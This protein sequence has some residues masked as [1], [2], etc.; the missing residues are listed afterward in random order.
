VK[1]PGS[2]NVFV[3]IFSAGGLLFV[4]A[5]PM[6]E[7]I[8]RARGLTLAE[9]VRRYGAAGKGDPPLLGG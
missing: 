2:G 6:V 9:V 8:A 7:V 5:G 4:E 1:V 3:S